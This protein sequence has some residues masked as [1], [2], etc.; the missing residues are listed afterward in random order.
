MTQQI[1]DIGANAND[2]TGEPLRQA[3]QAVNDNFSNIWAAG[4]VDSQVVIS[5]NVVSTNVT[6]LDLILAGN[7][8]GNVTVASTLVPSI[9][10]VYDLGNVNAQFDS[11]WARY[12]HGNGAYLTGINRGGSGGNVYFR[13]TPPL[14]PNIGDIWIDSDTAVQYLYFNDNT[15]NI[16]A[17][18]EAYQ[19][20]GGSTAEGNG[21]PGG[22][23][24]Q[25]Q[26][27]NQGSF[28]GSANLVYDSSVNQ[29]QLNGGLQINGA[30]ST[31]DYA[32]VSINVEG[33]YGGSTNYQWVFDNLGRLVIPTASSPE[34]ATILANSAGL[35]LQNNSGNVII[36]AS[37][38]YTWVL[39]S[40]GSL[41]LPAGDVI[42]TPVT[43]GFSNH[44]QKSIRGAIDTV[45]GN[46]LP[47]Y[48]S[49]LNQT[50]TIYTATNANVTATRMTLRVQYGDAPID[51]IEMCD[52][53]MAKEHGSN[54]NV[55]SSISNRLRTN[56]TLG[57]ANIS[58]ELDVGGNLIVL[59]TNSSNGD[60]YYTYSATEF[61]H[62]NG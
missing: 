32:N 39:T 20:F 1:I 49:V 51:G 50:E 45:F 8:I 19:S 10:S 58:V 2:G 62:T 36:S 14:N 7:G 40:T 23:N 22:S 42:S 41:R 30:I 12:Y 57:Y 5:N 13:Q 55:S 34:S 9:D 59:L 53:V 56:S 17:E 26:F 52:I 3:F 15:A 48:T 35:K 18:M 38:D 31:P 29:L 43:P 44:T 33:T 24:T 54:A 61:I 37:L 47:S 6:N 21:T 46:P 11:V 16:W 28:G 4:P 25:I 60:E 27:N